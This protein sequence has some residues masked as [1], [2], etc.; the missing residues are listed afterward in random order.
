YR[1]RLVAFYEGHAAGLSEDSRR[2]LQQ[3]PLRILDS[4]EPGDI[5]I[6]REAPDFRDH[7][8]AVSRDFFT[9]VADGL[10]ALGIPFALNPRLVRGLDYYCHTAFEFVTTELGA[11]GTVLGGGRYDGLMAVMGGPDTPG[12]GWAAGIERL[13]MLI[14][15]PP[16]PA[17]PIAVIPVGEAAELPALTL[18]ES[19]RAAGLT[20]DQ[21]YSGNLAKRMKRANRIGA[22]FAVLL[23]EDELKRE[24]ASLR[25]LDSGEQS[26][27]PLGALKGRL[28]AQG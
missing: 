28:A 2:R 22:R 25:D 23:G 7:L 24:A 21:A 20:V 5:A 1:A 26:E 6:N 4:K 17:R 13:A 3:N 14:A 12:I 11:Q 18:A 8:N 10:G 27:V 15:E 19:L 16:A 9:R